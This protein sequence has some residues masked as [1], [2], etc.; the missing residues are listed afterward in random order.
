MFLRLKPLKKTL[1][2]GVMESTVVFKERK[3]AKA[4]H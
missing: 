4:E 2:G 3:P 1:V